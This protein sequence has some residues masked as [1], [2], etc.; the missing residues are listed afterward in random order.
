MAP[1]GDILFETEWEGGQTTWESITQA[2]CDTDD[3]CEGT[4][5]QNDGAEFEVLALKQFLTQRAVPGGGHARK[6]DYMNTS[7]LLKAISRIRLTGYARAAHWLPLGLPKQHFEYKGTRSQVV[8][9]RE[10][11]HRLVAT[12]DIP[13][14]TDVAVLGLA[15]V[16]VGHPATIT[17]CKNTAERTRGKVQHCMPPCA[18]RFGVFVDSAPPRKNGGRIKHNCVFKAP[19]QCAPHMLIRTFR[20]VAKGEPLL[21]AYGQGSEGWTVPTGINLHRTTSIRK[22]N[23]RN[24]TRDTKS[25]QFA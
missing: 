8:K 21:C 10:G 12:N 23:G 3:M 24:A 4:L 25:G 16:A 5:Y 11:G 14:G 18:D 2:Y 20:R 6:K 19:R 7:F 9:T 1:N 22:H 17:W 13:E 15:Q